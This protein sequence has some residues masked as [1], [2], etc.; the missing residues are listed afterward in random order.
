MENKLL[1]EINQIRSNM[2]LSVI[3][4]N[5]Q[6]ILEAPNSGTLTRIFNSLVGTSSRSVLKT[7]LTVE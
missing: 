5:T 4:E 1:V 6:I 7:L 3:T 2:G